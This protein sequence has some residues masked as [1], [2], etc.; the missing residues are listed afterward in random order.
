MLSLDTAME[1]SSELL[2]Y[3]AAAS[4]TIVRFT[5]DNVSW[6]KMGTLGSSS[7]QIP[8]VNQLLRCFNV[9]E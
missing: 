2:C 9:E 6:G 8:L 5:R 7:V 1:E 4:D 3:T